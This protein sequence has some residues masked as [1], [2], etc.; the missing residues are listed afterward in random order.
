M[1]RD[2][3]DPGK[4]KLVKQVRCYGTHQQ[5]HCVEFEYDSASKQLAGAG[6]VLVTLPGYEERV[7]LCP[8]HV[9]L[10]FDALG[11]LQPGDE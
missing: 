8:K 7:W 5:P 10:V 3:I 2:G 9:R 4:D 1:S 11:P 6:W